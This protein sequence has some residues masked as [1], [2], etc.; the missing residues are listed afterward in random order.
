MQRIKDEFA[1]LIGARV[2][3]NLRAVAQDHH[4]VHKTLHLSISVE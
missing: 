3:G 2:P 4:L 1:L